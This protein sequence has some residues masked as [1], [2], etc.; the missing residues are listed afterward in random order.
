MPD[1]LTVK[2]VADLFAVS[3]RTV[4]SWRAAGILPAGRIRGVVRYRREAIEALISQSEGEAGHADDD[5]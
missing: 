1:L 5:R 4:R 2:Q 3:D